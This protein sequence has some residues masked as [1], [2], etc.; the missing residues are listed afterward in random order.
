MQKET[1][2]LYTSKFSPKERK[3]NKTATRSRKIETAK[4]LLV[5]VSILKLQKLQS[6]CKFCHLSPWNQSVSVPLWSCP[7]WR[8]Q[9]IKTKCQRKANGSETFQELILLE[10]VCTENLSKNNNNNNN[11]R[12]RRANATKK[13]GTDDRPRL[14]EEEEYDAKGRRTHCS[15]GPN[16]EVL[17]SSGPCYGISIVRHTEIGYL[18]LY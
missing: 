3:K 5:G 14:Y 2:R 16:F 9:N 17:K 6:A 7:L 1:S 13:I 12:P 8:N 4:G 15:A 10:A 18:S 11:A